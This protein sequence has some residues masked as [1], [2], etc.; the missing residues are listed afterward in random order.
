MDGRL[1]LFSNSKVRINETTNCNSV[2]TDGLQFI[3]SINPTFLTTTWSILF[4][5][6]SHIFQRCYKSSQTKRYRNNFKN[7][8]KLVKHL[9]KVDFPY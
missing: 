3:H 2:N 5:L 7:D 6:I 4:F 1:L 8:C 9:G